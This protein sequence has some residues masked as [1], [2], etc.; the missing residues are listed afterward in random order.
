MKPKSNTS[1]FEPNAFVH[2]RLN[3]SPLRSSSKKKSE[4]SISYQQVNFY[5]EFKREVDKGGL[6]PR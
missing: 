3:F 5:L 2:R 6:L 4:T 1:V